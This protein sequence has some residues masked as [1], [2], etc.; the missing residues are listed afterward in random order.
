M[1]AGKRRKAKSKVWQNQGYGFGREQ[2]APGR[3]LRGQRIEFAGELRSFDNQEDG[4]THKAVNFGMLARCTGNIGEV[5]S[6]RCLD[7]TPVPL[8]KIPTVVVTRIVA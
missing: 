7:K 3:Q 1:T 6:K 2:G 8:C 4:L 5:P